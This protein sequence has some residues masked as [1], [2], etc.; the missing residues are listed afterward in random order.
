MLTL[1][2]S[3]LSSLAEG[4]SDY[5]AYGDHYVHIRYNGSAKFSVSLQQHN[6]DCDDAKLPFPQTWDSVQASRYSSED[7]QDIYIPLSHF[8][9]DLQKVNGIALESWYTNDTTYVNKIEMLPPSAIPSSVSKVKKLDTGTLH[10]GCSQPNLIA[11]GIDDGSPEYMQE[12]LGIIKEEQIPVTFFVQGKALQ[13]GPEEGANF[14]AGYREMIDAG[15]QIALH[16]MS[17]PHMEAVQDEKEIEKQITDNIEI[18][19]N[20]LEVE[21]QYFRPPFGTVGSRTRQAV[22]RH[23]KDPKQVM[24]SIDVKDWMYGIDPDG[25]P[26]RKQYE[27]FKESL[28]KG[29]SASE[30]VP[31]Q[32][33]LPLDI[34]QAVFQLCIGGPMKAFSAAGS[35]GDS[36]M[37]YDG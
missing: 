37:G 23:I 15:H 33:Q 30:P 16:T 18:V 22:A 1:A 35:Q 13:L 28:N 10:V 17:H 20:K 21:S 2:A 36:R 8:N 31:N 5:S 25:D 4:C 34:P 12:T 6:K 11:F 14:T 24:W 9:V 29:V 27:A 26:G 7:K 3:F 19:K 32:L